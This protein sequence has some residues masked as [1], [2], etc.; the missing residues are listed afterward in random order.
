M[1][2]LFVAAAL[3]GAVA[4]G[5]PRAASDPTASLP[6]WEGRAAE[7]FDDSLDPAVLGLSIE[8]PIYRGDLLFRER[9]QA[10]EHV[11]RMKL[12]TVTLGT[13]EGKKTVTLGFTTLERLAGA[14]PPPT[15]EASFR[16]G[17]P[18]FGLIERMQGK[19]RGKTAVVAWRTFREDGGAVVHSVVA[20]DDPEVVAAVHEN[21]ALEDLSK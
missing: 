7:L 8:R 12:T 13:N 17:S 1:S 18:S 6:A 11:A 9:C 21:V 19:L 20:P 2:A 10:A 3:T 14:P 4:C 16:A 5:G 15:L